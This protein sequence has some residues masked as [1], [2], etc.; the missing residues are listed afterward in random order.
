MFISA[1]DKIDQ[2]LTTKII[3][4]YKSTVLGCLGGCHEACTRSNLISSSTVSQNGVNSIGNLQIKPI[5]EM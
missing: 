5:W 3:D 1:R 4:K 2:R